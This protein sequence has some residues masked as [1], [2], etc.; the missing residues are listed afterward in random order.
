MSSIADDAPS[1][2]INDNEHPVAFVKYGFAP[3]Q[4]NA[5]ETVLCMAQEGQPRWTVTTR[6]TRVVR[7]QYSPNDILVD[8]DAE[9]NVDLLRDARATESGV[10]SFQLDSGI[11]EF[12]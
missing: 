5:P 4:N 3:K 2:L 11:D 12:L 7:C 1:K 10:A 8:N 6:V 9:L